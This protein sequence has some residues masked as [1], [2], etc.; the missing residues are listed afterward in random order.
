MEADVIYDWIHYQLMDVEAV[1]VA[2]EIIGY[3]PY[4]NDLRS[5]AK[6]KV[7]GMNVEELEMFVGNADV[8]DIARKALSQAS[9]N[10]L[11]SGIM[12]IMDMS[13]EEVEK[14]INER[15]KAAEEQRQ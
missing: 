13:R 8:I 5:R 15:V 14:D 3:L 11:I 4:K 1:G 12:V 9:S 6:K 7:H 2:T 10:Q